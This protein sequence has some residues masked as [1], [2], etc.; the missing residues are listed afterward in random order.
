MPRS[1]IRWVLA[2]K[3]WD[4]HAPGFLKR[5]DGADGIDVWENSEALPRARLRSRSA[6]ARAPVL[7]AAILRR[8]PTE[9]EI[10][11]RAADDGARLA[12]AEPIHPGWR[13]TIDGAPAPLICAA[14]PAFRL[15]RW[16][17]IRWALDLWV[18]A[19]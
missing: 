4:P 7:P 3:G 8:S 12:I 19:G 2:P 11:A 13:A 14:P 16:V 5:F 6:P 15:A 1:T 18:V 17:S 10:R 9:I